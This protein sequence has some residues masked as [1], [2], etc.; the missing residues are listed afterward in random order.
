MTTSDI[1]ETRESN[2]RSYCRSFPATFKTARDAVLWDQE[3]RTY[4]DFFSGAGALNYGHNPPLLKKALIDYIS[5]DGIAHALD[6]HTSAKASF[7]EA[8]T[9]TIL[10]PRKLDYRV[11][12]PGPTGTN[13]VEAAMKLARK[14]TKRPNI[15]AFTNGFHGM[16]AGALAATGNAFNRRGAGMPLNGVDRYPYEGYFGPTID[17]TAMIRRLLE[18][19]SSGLEPPAAFLLETI[20][21]EGGLH[22]ANERW[23]RSL[24]ALAAELGSLIIIDDIQAGCGRTGTFFSFE[25]FGLH[26]DIVCLSKSISGFGLPMSLLLFDQRH[27]LWEPGEHNGTFRGNNLAFVTATAALEAWSDDA[28]PLLIEQRAR[29]LKE[30][31]AAIAHDLDHRALALRGRGLMQGLVCPTGDIA[32]AIS[33]KA[34]DLGLLIE[35]CGARG[36]VVKCLPPITISQEHLSVG[37]G[38]LSDAVRAVSCDLSGTVRAAE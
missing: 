4:I 20:Q 7:L 25:R 12:F 10:L 33:R 13:A 27:D 9:S 17:T 3:G 1:F 22:C 34:F 15:A 5:A 26:P 38:K 18:D 32:A 30:G 19:P 31:L 11:M 2:V 36:E 24:A 35:T 21:G 16:S 28:F 23:L 37:L 8:F 14:V 6:L 29:Q